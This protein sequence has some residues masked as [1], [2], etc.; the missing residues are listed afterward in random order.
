MFGLFGLARSA[1]MSGCDTG[2]S[3]PIAAAEAAKVAVDRICVAVDAG[4]SQDA[5]HAR[6]PKSR[7]QPHPLEREGVAA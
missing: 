7:E 5:G 3:S 1:R 6:P 4:L 2:H